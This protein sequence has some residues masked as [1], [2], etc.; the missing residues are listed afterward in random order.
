MR[1]VKIDL[2]HGEVK[3][4]LEN[5][6]D[7]WELSKVIEKG[8]KVFARTFRR[9]EINRGDESVK[10]EKRP[11]FLGIEIE[12]I[13][14]HEATGNLRLT[15]KIIEGPDDMSGYHTI[16]LEAGSEAS[17]MKE[18]KSW[19]IQRLKEAMIKV[20]KV[21]VC[22]LDDEEAT[23]ATIEKK[24]DVVAEL[25]GPGS[26]KEFGTRNKSEY[27][28]DIISFLSKTDA[29]KIIIAGPGFCKEELS[30]L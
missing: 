19:E 22:I 14:F 27:F 28:G 4:V 3:I 30:K 9:V 23:I 8:N 7:L 13:E 17:V 24:I 20:P 16:S 21:L 11:V 25:R 5:S 2:R 10:G 29:E 26:G 18:W 6:N 15:G 12:K 1:I